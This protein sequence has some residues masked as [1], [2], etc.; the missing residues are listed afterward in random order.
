LEEI[1]G[2]FDLIIS[3]KNDVYLTVKT[4]K[5]IA[6]ELSDFFTFEVPGAKFM[7]QYRNRMWD[8]KIR[9]FSMQ[10]GEIYFGLLSYIEEFAKR[11]DIEIEYKEGVKDEE[12][13]RDGELDTFIG[14]VSPQS[15]GQNIQI[16]DY[17]MAALDYAIRNN[18]SLLLSPTAS[19]KSLII[20]IL[21]VWYASK[22]ES[23]ILILVPTTSLVEQMHSDFLDYG[24]KE[25][26]MQKIYQGYS[27]NITKPITI[28]TWQS[29][30]KMQKKWFDQFSCI[31]G[32]EVHIFKSK[33]LTG[34]MNKMVNCKYRHGFTGTLDGTQTHRLVLEGLFGSVNKVTTTKELMDSDTLAKLS[35]ECIV[36]RY[37]D[38]DCKYMKNLSYQDEVDLI[39]R[40]ERRNKFIVD[41][42]K[43][44]T[45]NTLV[46]F[47]FVEKHGDVLHTMINT[48]LT[49]RKVFYVYGGTDTQTRE[50]I[51]SI[52]EKEK[53]AV[54]V[55]SYGTFST[56]INIRNLHNI[57]FA[58]PSKSRIR[59]LQSV[60]RALRLGDNKVSARLVD[61]ADD[62]TY[63]GKQNFTLRHFM[64]RIN[65][66]NE[67][68][69][70]Y[71]I[72][73]ISIDKG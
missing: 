21:S 27:K 32:D 23:N 44:L 57:V 73:Q 70:D 62:F 1:H 33:S 53:D 26:M 12:R 72:K 54:I 14:R 68:E 65:I 67:E 6:R 40:D 61:I 69:F 17:Q 66:Y 49:D 71:D 38:A 8:G 18:R 11:N 16:R 19:G 51:R 63:K 30:Y 13:L 20:Y 48:S 31:L 15:K 10:T 64:E 59:V 36:L 50:E 43:H 46:L 60:G 9:L 52:T 4:D 22:T 39:V 41:L 3:K 45:G 35:V 25:S 2:R 34:I 29:V 55:A 58:S 47:Q 37:P 24:F 42:T 5:G 28:S 56:G 7:P